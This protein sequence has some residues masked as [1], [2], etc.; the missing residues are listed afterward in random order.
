[1]NGKD[2]GGSGIPSPLEMTGQKVS[3]H[4]CRGGRDKLTGRLIVECELAEN[5]VFRALL[6]CSSRDCFDSDLVSCT[7]GSC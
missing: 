6:A 1:M 4:I 5:V 7:L 2:I 3:E